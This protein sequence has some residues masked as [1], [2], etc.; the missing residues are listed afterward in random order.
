MTERANRQVVWIGGAGHSGSTLLGLCL[1]SH[2]DMLYAGEA[3]KSALL[4]DPSKPLKKRA[5]K[6][7]GEAP[8]PVW[9]GLD[10]SR[11]D[12]YEALSARTGRPVIVDSTKRVE[13]VEE[14]L[15]RLAGTGVSLAYVLL[16]RDGRAVVASRMRKYPEAGVEAHA[17]DWRE[18]IE[19]C[20]ALA[21]RFDGAVLHIR[22]ERLATEPAE[23][24]SAICAGL[25]R[26]YD[27]RMLRFWE[28][29][30]HP[31][32]GN[33]GTQSLVLRERGATHVE[34][35]KKARGYYASHARGFVLDEPSRDNLDASALE[36]F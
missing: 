12:L 35:E 10:L 14:Q 29:E 19:A 8:C 31:L 13:W 33:N 15:G 27:A 9:S 7:C 1:G 16:E 32:G 36:G 4:G 21:D 23:V 18:Q 22:Y 5:C 24:L 20:R 2:P 28:P 11:T 3:K 34:P 17:R 30:H 25:G 6:L 26:E